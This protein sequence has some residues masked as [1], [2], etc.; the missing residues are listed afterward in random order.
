MGRTTSV[1]VDLFLS[2][3]SGLENLLDSVNA[4][5]AEGIFTLKLCC[6]FSS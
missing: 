5:F 3:L 6:E 1:V 4:D 2:D